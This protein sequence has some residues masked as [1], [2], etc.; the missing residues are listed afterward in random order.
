MLAFSVSAAL[1][2]LLSHRA[3]AGSIDTWGGSAASTD[4]ATTGNWSYS[5]GTGP[6]ASGDSLVFTSANASASANLT[7]TLTSNTF[8][9]NGITFNAGSVAYSMTGNAF[10]LSSGSSIINSGTNLESFGNAIT[11]QGAETFSTTTGGGNLSFSGV[12]SGAGPLVISG[13]GTTIL[14]AS[15]TYTGGTTISSGTLQLGNGTSASSLMNGSYAISSGARLYLDEG[16]YTNP[17]SGTVTGTGTFE[18]NATANENPVNPELT[19]SFTGTLAVDT[20]RLDQNVGGF[21]GSATIAINSG[22]EIIFRGGTSALNFDLAGTGDGDGD[23]ALRVKNISNGGGELFTGNVLLTGPALIASINSNGADLSAN[24]TFSGVIS[25]ASANTLT[26]SNTSDTTYQYF[27]SGKNTYAGATV[28]PAGTVVISGT[29]DLGDLGGTL[30]GSYAGNITLTDS[31]STPLSITGGPSVLQYASS[32]NQTFS[33]SI[34]GAGSLVDSGTGPLTLTGSNSYTGTT[35]LGSGA[36]LNLVT[37][38]ALYSGNTASFTPANITIASAGTLAVNVG[39]PSD[40]TASQ[41]G[42]LLSNLQTGSTAGFKAGSAFTFNTNNATSAV[43]ISQAIGNATG[44]GGGAFSFTKTGLG[45]LILSAASNSYTGTTTVTNGELALQGANNGTGLEPAC[46]P[47]PT[48]SRLGRLFCRFRIPALWVP[49]RPAQPP[50][51]RWP[52]FT[53]MPPEPRSPAPFLRSG[54]PSVQTPPGITTTSR[55]RWSIRT[56]TTLT[57]MA[58]PIRLPRFLS[59][60]TVRSCS[61]PWAIRMM[62]WASRL[63]AP[64]P[65]SSIF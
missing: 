60:A 25:G 7:D 53:S 43:T 2:G 46:L 3:Q 39:G 44:T 54:R 16:T 65:G 28:I 42:A 9:I 14:T 1:S 38:N 6:V 37:G 57:T 12:I 35:T 32:V 27:L 63:S 61:D 17:T 30:G 40:F 4:W 55:I 52:G 26:I 18:I 47:G 50:I 5:S 33:G 20:G 56:I 24:V 11:L 41:V 19:G 8:L 31:P 10:E 23:G 13:S 48:S 51:H 21:G 29:G 62:G 36:T 59:Q 34:S 64:A 49:T 45:T 58:M 22:G 15:G